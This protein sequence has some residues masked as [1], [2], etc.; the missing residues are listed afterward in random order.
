MS[1]FHLSP[2][3][4][5]HYCQ[6]IK[7][8]PYHAIMGY[9]SALQALAQYILDTGERGVQFRTAVTSGEVLHARQRRVIQQA[10]G[11][12][13]FDQYGCTEICV[14]AAQ[15]QEGSM[16]ISP[17]YGVLEIV[18]DQGKPVP[19]GIPGEIICTGLLNDVHILIRYRLGDRGVLSDEPCRCGS[20]FPVLKSIE[21]RTGDVFVLPNGRRLG[22][23]GD[24]MY[25]VSSVA[26]WQL[27]QETPDLFTVWV[28]PG[29]GFTK[30]DGEQILKNLGHDLPGV[31]IRIKTVPAIERGPGGKRP[32]YVSLLN[33]GRPAASS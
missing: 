16:H 27:V 30:T 18:D 6:E 4:L 12:Q 5:S 21:G 20:P 9:P 29:K 25:G 26:E 33:P 13:V 28:V 8:R 15:C 32:L 7:K 2:T 31:T 1:V 17:D 22:I 3:Y 19:P 10:F 24:E 14:F 23:L 11:C